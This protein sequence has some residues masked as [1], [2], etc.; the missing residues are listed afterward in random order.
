MFNFFRS[1]SG[2]KSS[3]YIL[4]AIAAVFVSMQA[5]VISAGFPGGSYTDYN[6]YIIFRRSFSHLVS[7]FDL[8]CAYPTEYW[9]LYKYSPTFAF[10]MGMFSTLP[11]ALGLAIWNL[12]NATALF[13]A[14]K[15]LRLT[16]KAQDTILIFILIELITSMQNAQSNALLAGFM[17]AAFAC[18]QR[19]RPVWAAL[20]L[21][22]AT[23]IKVYGA[24]G[25]CL[26]LFYPNKGRFIGYSILFALLFL[27]APLL[28]TSPATLI[29]QYHN[30]A[31]MMTRDVSGSFGI[32]MMGL[33]NSWFGVH[34]NAALMLIGVILFI[35]PFSR[36]GLYHNTLYRYKVLSF[37]LIW[38]IIF[39][40]KAESPTYI[41]AIAGV[42]IW[43]FTSQKTWWQTALIILTFIFTCLAPTDIFPESVRHNYFEP[44]A[45]KAIPCVLIWSILLI[46]LAIM[47]EGTQKLQPN[48]LR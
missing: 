10:F 7:G 37:T 22:A 8:Y 13:F 48:S 16:G 6:N 42:A 1:L 28:V 12:L 11:N 41:I 26:F 30:W 19:G 39:N 36:T 5:I 20:W 23:F 4:Y 34:N 2:H 21:V 47:K 27:V 38:I 9:D 24:A 35:I 33:V 15:K 40:S 17:I 31:A 43:Y 25:F 32:S 3:I 29:W 46:R 44:Y 18:F 45:V 14:I